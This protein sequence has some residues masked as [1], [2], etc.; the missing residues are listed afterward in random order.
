M[1][2]RWFVERLG[3]EYKVLPLDIVDETSQHGLQAYSTSP[4]D[5]SVDNEVVTSPN[6]S[7]TAH[8][9][10]QVLGILVLLHAKGT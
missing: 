8:H 5:K 3:L 9:R 7:H 4:F 2:P 6:F 1:R 10:A